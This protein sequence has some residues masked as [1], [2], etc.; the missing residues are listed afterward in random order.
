MA[1]PF[2]PTWLRKNSSVNPNA[3]AMAVS[4][5]LATRSLPKMYSWRSLGRDG[6]WVGPNCIRR[7]SSSCTV[8]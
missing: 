4:T 5:P 3:L 8:R 1:L 6:G 2:S 7:S